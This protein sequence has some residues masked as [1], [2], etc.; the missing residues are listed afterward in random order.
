MVLVTR[1]FG[2]MAH[3]KP[4][5]WRFAWNPARK[6]TVKNALLRAAPDRAQGR[7]AIEV[8]VTNLLLPRQQ[9]EQAW[10]Y[11]VYWWQTGL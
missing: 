10:H 8:T 11:L 9:Y 1:K 6:T 7:F 2:A 5:A 3:P 4:R